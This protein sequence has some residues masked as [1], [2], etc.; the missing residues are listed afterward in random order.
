MFP[1]VAPVLNSLIPA[2]A[3]TEAVAGKRG[4]KFFLFFYACSMF[5]KKY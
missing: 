1:H 5:L 2:V 3:L 4:K